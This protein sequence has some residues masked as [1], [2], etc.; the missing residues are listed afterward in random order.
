MSSDIIIIVIIFWHII[1]CHVGEDPFPTALVMIV[2]TTSN[3]CKPK[4]TETVANNKSYL[5]CNL[6]MQIVLFYYY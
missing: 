5:F 2:M 4:R 3:L 1:L 6:N